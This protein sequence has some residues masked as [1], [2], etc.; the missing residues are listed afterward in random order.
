MGKR[1]MKCCVFLLLSVLL[2]IFFVSVI[3]LCCLKYEM[4]DNK[5]GTAN[6]TPIVITIYCVVLV[7]KTIMRAPISIVLRARIVTERYNFF[8]MIKYF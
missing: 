3:F 7:G 1:V 4:I 2:P 8:V 5:P 6:N